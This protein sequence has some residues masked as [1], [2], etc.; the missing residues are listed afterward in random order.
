MLRQRLLH[1][2][3]AQDPARVLLEARRQLTGPAH[4]YSA[5]P[6]GAGPVM[7]T[8]TVTRN[9]PGS[10]ARR[11]CIARFANWISALTPG[12]AASRADLR[13]LAARWA[14]GAPPSAAEAAA[15]VEQEVQA[16]ERIIA[17]QARAAGWHLGE[18]GRLRTWPDGQKGAGR[19]CRRAGTGPDNQR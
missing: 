4:E 7:R 6:S 12:N 11:A 17:R 5:S 19:P 14:P 3:T 16:L 10:G 15:A 1:G 8:I 9:D 13:R 18:A 2:G